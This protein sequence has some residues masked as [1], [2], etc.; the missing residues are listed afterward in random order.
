MGFDAALYPPAAV[1]V[2]EQSA[3][4]GCRD[5][6]PGAKRAV[7]TRNGDLLGVDGRGPAAHHDRG[8]GEIGAS[9]GE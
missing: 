7:G 9:S 6:E 5:V 4:V 3:G 2:D 1:E 8:S